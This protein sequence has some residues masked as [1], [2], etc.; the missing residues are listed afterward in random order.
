MAVELEFDCKVCGTRHEPCVDMARL[1][2][3][4]R[5]IALEA[6]Q[7]AILKLHPQDG[8][9]L[10]VN[11]KAVDVAGFERACWPEGAKDLHLIVICVNTKPGLSVKDYLHLLPKEE[12][13]QILQIVAEWQV[14]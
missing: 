8:D 3:D 10:F 7:N 4:A 9:F 1:L 2:R 14:Q 11:W 13:L 5:Q 6:A 12:A